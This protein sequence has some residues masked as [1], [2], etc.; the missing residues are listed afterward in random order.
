MNIKFR[1]CI[2]IY[3]KEIELTK[4]I[5]VKKKFE[6]LGCLLLDISVGRTGD[7]QKW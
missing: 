5:S 7:T 1:G 4:F 3:F 2:Q 6:I